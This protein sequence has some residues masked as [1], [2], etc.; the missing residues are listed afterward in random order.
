VTSASVITGCASALADQT[1]PTLAPTV[2]SPSQ[3]DG[4]LGLSD[5]ASEGV[6]DRA[7]L[8][9][10]GAA[11][12]GDLLEFIPGMVVTQHS[13]DGK[14]NQYFLRGFNLDHG[15]DFATRV[16]GMP[17]NMPSHGH[18]QGYTDLNFVIPEL[19][20]RIDYRKGPYFATHG[21]FASAGAADLSYVTRL[22]APLAM[23]TTGRYN[24]RRALLAGSTNI[25]IDRSMLVALESTTYDGPWTIP[26]Q[27][28]RKNAVLRLQ[29][30][31]SNEGLNI[32]LMAYQARWVATDQVPQ[33][34]IDAGSY[35]GRPFGRFDSLDPSDGGQT[36]RYSLSSQWHQRDRDVYTQ[37][38][39]YVIQTRLRLYSNFTFALDAPATGDQFAQDDQRKVVG[40]NASRAWSHRLAGLESRSE[41]GVQLRHDRIRLGLQDTQAR[42]V[43]AT[44]RLDDVNQTLLGVYGQSKLE[45]NSW[46]R[47]VL[48]LRAD[49]AAFAVDSLSLP[50]NSGRTRSR[51]LSPKFMLIASPWQ[52]TEMYF[53]AGRGFHSNDARGTT[54]RV[55][56]KT[57]EP[58]EPSPGLSASRGWELGL[59]TEA[60]ANLQSSVALWRLNF[61]SELSYVGD[62]GTTAAGSASQRYGLEFNN[63]W[64]AGKQLRL[65]ADLALTHAR[66][67]N[68]ER[69]PNA[70]DSVVSVTAS[71]QNLGA[72]S[73][74]LHW[75]YLGSGALTGDNSARSQPGSTVSWRVSR[76]LL[77]Q[78]AH[79]SSLTLDIF[80]LFNRRLNDIQ[81]YYAT[82]LPTEASPVNDR[83]VHPAEPRSLRLTWSSRF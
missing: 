65:D 38:S 39:A 61:D 4:A 25:G 64:Q 50:A 56:P 26:E 2:V 59:R 55:D 58:L 3:G 83:L 28:Q 70:I 66:L 40:L 15:T 21:D 37:V 33:R 43:L 78:T 71:L 6:V 34:L 45:L 80:N 14:A 72:W 63:R 62:A 44:T 68:G 5:T 77:T 57:G 11:R 32:S 24:Y 36:S 42:Q 19:V 20:E 82:R 17:V 60:I 46:L 49:S 69:I 1:Q 13:G 48:G 74:S 54:A 22:D 9:N 81:Y 16:D 23:V 52:H 41:I 31:N 51:L 12:P 18:G 67:A 53:S 73:S 27:L 79:P 75:R 29:Q 7:T 8:Q 30:G 10:R 35:Q 47:T 76:K